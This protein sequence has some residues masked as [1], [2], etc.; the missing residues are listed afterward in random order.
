MKKTLIL[1]LILSSFSATAD[2]GFNFMYSVGL[3]TGGDNLAQTNIG[4]S[5]KSG[6]LFYFAIGSVYQFTDSN[7]QLQGTI[8]YHFDSLDAENGS[9]DFDRFQIELI[10]FYKVSEN[11]RVG[12]GITNVMSAE[13]TFLGDTIGF[14]DS[15]GIVAELN[16][17]ISNRNWWGI[18][19]VDLDFTADSLNGFNISGLPPLDGSYIGLMFNA[20]F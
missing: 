14:E 6:G 4:S 2:D 19:Y 8:G 18:R 9:A 3:T 15:V 20:G 11:F 16:W 7:F 13:F 12:L 10:P 17:R 1:T 5:L